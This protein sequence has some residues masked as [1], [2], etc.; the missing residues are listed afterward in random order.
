MKAI[1]SII[2]AAILSVAVAEEEVHTR[3]NLTSEPAGAMIYIDGRSS[4]VTPHLF[5]DLALGTHIVK[6]SLPGYVDQDFLIEVRDAQLVDRYEVLEEERG[7]FVLKTEPEGCNIKIDGLT[8]GESPRLITH[9]TTKDVHKV[10]LSKTGYLSQTFEVKFNGREPIVREERLV[11]DAGVINCETEPA[12]AKVMVNGIV[13][14]KTP[15]TVG[16]IPKGVVVVKFHLDGYKDESREL[17]INAGEEQTLSVPLSGLPGSLHLMA[18]PN[19]A[20]FYVNNKAQG[21]GPISISALA[22]GEYSVRC[23]KEGYDTLSRVV[24]IHN[25]AAT[26]EEFKLESLMGRIE[27]RTSPGGAEVL[28]DGQSAGYTHGR[29]EDV[30]SDTFVIENVMAGEHTLILRKDGYAE[31]SIEVVV[32]ARTT[33]R[34]RVITLKRAFVPN[35]EVT[36]VSEKVRGVFKGQNASAIIIETKPGVEYPIPR[37]F[38][39]QIDYLEK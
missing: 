16:N 27:V 35:V 37:Q 14:G 8:V 28:M 12:G 39:R 22:P 31:S 23:E 13:R 15:L 33:A 7:L 3:V 21:K 18:T 1:F 30:A 17:R 38:I 9:L 4:G 10:V 34:P 20:I 19:D 2:L 24:T 5:F 32:N 25:A 29:G 11:L 26:H 36:T 6:Y